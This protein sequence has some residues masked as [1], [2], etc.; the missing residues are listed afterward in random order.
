[1]IKHARVILSW[2]TQHREQQQTTDD[3]NAKPTE[4]DINELT[5]EEEKNSQ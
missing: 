3:C 1:V 4:K 5:D 2:M